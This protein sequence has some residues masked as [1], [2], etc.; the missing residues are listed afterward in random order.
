MQ[1]EKHVQKQFGVSITEKLQE[2]FA[3]EEA[4]VD[5]LMTNVQ[6]NLNGGTFKFVVLMD[7][8]HRQLKD[9]ILFMNRNSQFDVYAVELEYYKHQSYEI[10]IPKIFGTE[11]KKDVISA[12]SSSSGRRKWDE[13]SYWQEV[14]SKLDEPKVRSL[15]KVYDWA[16]TNADHIRWGTGMTRG[17]FNPQFT[18]ISPISFVSIFSDGAVQVSYGYLPEDMELRQR[19]R[20]TLKRYIDVPGVTDVS[21][22][23]LKSTYRSIPPEYVQAHADE[24]VEALTD[25]VKS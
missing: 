12:K 15:R 23:A 25:F 4:G 10:I 6:G 11:V 18:H 7:S 22:G 16:K 2:F 21:D 3:I 1:L 8:L 17:S 24:I 14:E 9:L 20:E 13:S 19:L 5:F